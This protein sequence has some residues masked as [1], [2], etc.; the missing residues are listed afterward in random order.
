MARPATTPS[1]RLKV[2]ARA[3][4]KAEKMK[5]GERVTAKPMAELLEVS[6]PALRGWC[7]D[8]PGFAESGAFDRGGNGVEYSFLALKTVNVLIKHFERERDRRAGKARRA[9]KIIGA[10]G[11]V[12]VPEDYGL[13]ETGKMLRLS[14]EFQD[15]KAR[16]GELVRR[17]EIV[18]VLNRTFP[19]MLQAG[20]MAAQQADPNGRWSP[21][22]RT[23]A[24]TVARMILSAQ[25]KI[26]Q[27]DLVR[28]RGGA[29]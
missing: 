7:D 29:A 11:F 19:E 26:V 20:L 14:I 15:A 4:A 8:I 21:D 5:R 1:A 24:Q 23:A 17:R 2:L 13:D 3:K 25:E 12:D 10:E 6:W 9:R 18:D 27:R 16:S 22:Q 28:I